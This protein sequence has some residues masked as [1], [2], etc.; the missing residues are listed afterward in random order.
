MKKVREKYP[1]DLT[2]TLSDEECY[3][4]VPQNIGVNRMCFYIESEMITKIVA[5]HGVDG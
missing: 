3:V 1:D 4:Y 2:E 5:L